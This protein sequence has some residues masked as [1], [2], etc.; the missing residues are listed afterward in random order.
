MHDLDRAMFESGFGG[1]LPD[2]R[3]SSEFEQQEFQ[4][5][6]GEILGEGGGGSAELHES[7]QTELALELL[8]I[9]SEQELDRFLGDL[10]SRAAGAIRDFAGSGTGRALTD[11]AKTAVGQALPVVGQAVGTWI[12]PRFGEYGA[13]AGRAAGSLLGLELEGL[14]QEDRELTTARALIR[15]I[16]DAVRRAS[17]SSGQAPPTQAARSAAVGAAQRTVPGLVQVIG[18]LPDPE[19]PQS[20]GPGDGSRGGEQSGRWVRRG[21]TV[22]LYGL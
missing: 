20:I 22:V 14:S 4:E 11:I 15:W 17:S 12:D 21:D 19:A 5:L 16:I 6:L 10:V 3:E 9:S 13:R 1:E 8:E 2:S 7:E 18:R